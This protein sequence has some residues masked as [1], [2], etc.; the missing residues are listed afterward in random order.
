MLPLFENK[1]TDCEDVLKYSIDLRGDLVFLVLFSDF[2]ETFYSSFRISV[3]DV[4][5]CEFSDGNSKLLI[6]QLAGDI[7][8]TGEAGEYWVYSHGDIANEE[9]VLGTVGEVLCG[10][11]IQT[12]VWSSG[13]SGPEILVGKKIRVMGENSGKMGIL[14]SNFRGRS[15]VRRG[16]C[17][18][19]SEGA[20]GRF[21]FQRG[22]EN[23]DIWGYVDQMVESAFL[24]IG[25]E[26]LELSSEIIGNMSKLIGS[27]KNAHILGQKIEIYANS[28]SAFCIIGE[29][30]TK[31]IIFTIPSN[32][33]GIF[34]VLL[35]SIFPILLSII[36]CKKPQLLG[37]LIPLR[38]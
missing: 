22:I 14:Q 6:E 30:A 27:T 31:E 18:F 35:C 2:S 17:R 38:Q 26:D 8:L 11:N 3:P 9:E 5:L 28:T 32:H 29:Y 21:V 37:S 33:Y 24:R 12:G 23:V 4:F 36:I 15:E 13:C 10:K 25:E 34:I 1:E 20:S 16:I 19:V 7:K